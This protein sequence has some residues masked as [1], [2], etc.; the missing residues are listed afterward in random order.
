MSTTSSPSVEVTELVGTSPDVLASG[1]YLGMLARIDLRTTPFGERLAWIFVILQAAAD[2]GDFEIIGWTG[3]KTHKG[4][5]AGDWV[6]AITGRRLAKDE[7]LPVSEMVGVP[8]QLILRVDDLSGFDRLDG[9]VPAPKRKP[10]PDDPEEA[11]AFA[12]FIAQRQA[13]AEQDGDH[14]D[15]A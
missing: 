3:P 13:A 9:V 1:V 7:H 14:A 2:G 8:V 11:A 5:K 15:P 6:E 10:E 4:T 12:A